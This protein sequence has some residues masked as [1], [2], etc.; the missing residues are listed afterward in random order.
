MR[1]PGGMKRVG[2]FRRFGGK[3]DGAAIGKGRGLAVDRQRHRE[4]AGLAAIENAMAVDPARRNSE[5]AE[6][7]VVERFCLFQV[8]GADHDVREHSVFLPGVRRTMLVSQVR[9][10]GMNAS[11]AS[12]VAQISAAIRG[13]R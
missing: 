3:A 12:G 4:G 11:S 2:G 10:Y 8:V 13:L 1:Y 5:R 6:Q 7:R 9:F